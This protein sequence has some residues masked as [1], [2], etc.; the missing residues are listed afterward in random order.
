MDLTNLTG[1]VTREKEKQF[2]QPNFMASFVEESK[3]IDLKTLSDGLNISDTMIEDQSEEEVVEQEEQ[4]GE[5]GE[6]L[7]VSDVIE[8]DDKTDASGERE[9]SE[10]QIDVK[11]P[12]SERSE[13][14]CQ[15]PAEDLG[16]TDL[17]SQMTGESECYSRPGQ[18]TTNTLIMSGALPCLVPEEGG[19][20]SSEEVISLLS[21]PGNLVIAI[22]LACLHSVTGLDLLNA[23]SLLLTI[24]SF[25]SLILQ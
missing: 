12:K 21:H 22:F 20:A 24:V 9:E 25:V 11:F 2:P 16:V 6:D 7:Q 4:E 14:G 23:F 18:R 1:A 17:L 8:E 5:E 3:M 15:T 19:K 10:T 13:S